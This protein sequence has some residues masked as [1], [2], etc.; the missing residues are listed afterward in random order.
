M[1]YLFSGL[2]AIGFGGIVGAYFQSMFQQRSSVK[3]REHELKRARY[4]CILILMLTKLDPDAGLPQLKLRRPEL[5]SAADL[6]QELEVELL[7]SLLFASDAT[8]ESISAFIATPSK[9]TFHTAAIAMRKDL[10]G[11]KSKVKESVLDVAY[12]GRT[13]S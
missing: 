13:R 5:Q 7:N 11:S 3:E 8:V 9:R 6:D 4:G 12:I 10:W 1:E 2:A